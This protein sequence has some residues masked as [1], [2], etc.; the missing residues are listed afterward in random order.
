[1]KMGQQSSYSAEL[2]DQNKSLWLWSASTPVSLQASRD[3]SFKAGL[4]TK[5]SSLGGVA[6]QPEFISPL[7]RCDPTYS[8]KLFLQVLG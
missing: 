4:L 5:M 7:P 8:P 2:T 6:L 3:L 1:M